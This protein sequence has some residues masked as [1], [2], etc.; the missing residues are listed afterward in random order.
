MLILEGE[1]G[2]GKSHAAVFEAVR[3]LIEGRIEKILIGR[4]L[5]SVDE[6]YGF[7][8]GTL[9][10]K[11]GPWLGA[12]EDVLGPLWNELHR[13]YAGQIQSVAVGMTRG[14]TIK[15]AVMLI[16]EAQNL[17]ASQ[18]KMLATRVGENGK[19]ILSGD[20]TQSDLGPG[21]AV[22][23]VEFAGRAERVA[24][25]RVVRFLPCDQ[26]RSEFV[27]AMVTALEGFR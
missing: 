1:A 16:D 6:D 22:P 27:R 23:L 18:L 14:R 10:E 4:P 12:F 15:N 8:P 20:G 2:T 7:L 11:L 13:R 25:C 19:L 17:K 5:V 21:R 24:G 26:M 3:D 9:E